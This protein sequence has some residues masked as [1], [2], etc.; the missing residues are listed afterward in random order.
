MNFYKA[1]LRTPLFKATSL[2]SINV[3]LK[4]LTGLATSKILAIF[5]G[6]SGMAIAGNFKNF[7]T[8]VESIATLGFQ[9]GIV[10]YIVE[11]KNDETQFKKVFSTVF[12]SLL[13][14][15]VLLS[16]V[17]FGFASYWSST[18]LDNTPQYQNA[19]KVLALVLPWYAT[20]A[21]LIVV[22][23]GLGKYRWVIYTNIIGNIIGLLFCL[24]AVWYFKTMGALLSIIIPPALLFFV[25]FYYL[26]REI[27]FFEVILSKT[28][29][30]Q[31]L[32]NLSSY[33]LMA[34]VS[35]VVGS[36]VI[37]A[38]RKHTI[39]VLGL[40]KAGYWEAMSR[41]SNYY[42]LFISTILAVYFFPK[43]AFATTKKA[44]KNVFWSYYKGIMPLF[45]AGLFVLFLLR[46]WVIQLIFTKDFYPV[47][48]LFLWQL[49]GD[50]FKAASLI[51]GYQFFA[52]K[53]TAAFIATELFS[54][55]MM[56]GFSYF[57]ITVFDIQ[58]VVMGYA[59]AYFIYWLTLV[60]YFRKQLF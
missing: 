27:R 48:D 2:N 40:E 19:F 58:G 36:W 25:V 51:L 16:I 10:K 28:F 24:G 26:N 18:V 39:V 52:K 54:L 46:F 49:L 57:L 17:L 47:A 4:I 30:V 33:S 50:V 38:I 55:S 3:L 1:I 32:R 44:T 37:L 21:F 12:I 15:S 6:P 9:N 13:V 59:L 20:T 56:Y 14:V 5:I 11:S 43:L 31:V 60:I 8:S 7:M 42:L 29:D 22:L 53:L 34:L 45:L 23:N 41:I 35:S